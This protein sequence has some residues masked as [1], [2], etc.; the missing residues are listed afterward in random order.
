MITRAILLAA[1]AA[2]LLSCTDSAPK[3]TSV[4]LG[5]SGTLGDTV[6]LVTGL[7]YI[8]SRVGSGT[9]AAWCQ[10]ATFQYDAFL[11]DGTLWDTSAGLTSPYIMVPGMGNLPG[12]EQGIIGMRPGGQRHLIIPTSLGFGNTLV[13]FHS[14]SGTTTL[15]PPGSMLFYDITL[16]SAGP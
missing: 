15:I 6:V 9:A 13:R 7:E 3:C 10:A 14:Q 16:V 11:A 8:E 1:S 5:Q 2:A 12:L 4:A